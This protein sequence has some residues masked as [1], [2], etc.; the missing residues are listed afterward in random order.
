MHFQEPPAESRE[1]EQEIVPGGDP[2]AGM[3]A[4]A[5]E[6]HGTERGGDHENEPERPPSP[7]LLDTI[8]EVNVTD[9]NTSSQQ[10]QETD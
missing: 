8:D 6:T 2:D 1:E 3:P 5:A 10:L 4:E 9:E 7:P